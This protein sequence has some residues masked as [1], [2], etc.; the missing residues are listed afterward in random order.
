MVSK[1]NTW[2]TAYVQYLSYQDDAIIT[3]KYSIGQVYF[4]HSILFSK[5]INSNECWAD[6]DLQASVLLS[7]SQPVASLTKEINQRLAKRPLFFNGRLANRGLTEL[8]ECR[9]DNCS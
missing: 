7:C 4:K 6:R 3:V 5:I 8:S 1:Y 9:Y 2:N